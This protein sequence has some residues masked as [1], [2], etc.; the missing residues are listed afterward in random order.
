M[1]FRSHEDGGERAGRPE[2]RR[3]GR[4]LERALGAEPAAAAAD[5]LADRVHARGDRRA[6]RL[7]RAGVATRGQVVRVGLESDLVP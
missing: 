6:L 3:G 5:E 2:D 4:P 7:G 1:L